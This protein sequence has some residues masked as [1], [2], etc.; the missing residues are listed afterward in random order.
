MYLS[1]NRKKEKVYRF[2]LCMG[3]AILD[4]IPITLYGILRHLV[5]F[6]DSKNLQIGTEKIFLCEI[7]PKP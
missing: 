3:K 7:E 6:F 5:E 2:A 4:L 1:A